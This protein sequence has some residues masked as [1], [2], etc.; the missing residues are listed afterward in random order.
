MW[1]ARNITVVFDA[2][3]QFTAIRVSERYQGFR[4][5]MVGLTDQSF[6]CT[7]APDTTERRGAAVAA[8]TIASNEGACN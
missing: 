2:D 5:L 1:N 3:D 7:P 6:T 4:D 8:P